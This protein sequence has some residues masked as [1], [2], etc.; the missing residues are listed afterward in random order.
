[1]TLTDTAATLRAECAAQLYDQWQGYYMLQTMLFD[2]WC[3][4][5]PL[6]R[7]EAL[8]YRPATDESLRLM[9]PGCRGW[10]E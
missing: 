8:T 5:R 1:M 10:T 3:D 6:T 4:V 7:A 9:W 2:H